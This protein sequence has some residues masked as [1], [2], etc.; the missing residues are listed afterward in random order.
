MVLRGS[1]YIGIDHLWVKRKEKNNRDKA[2]KIENGEIIKKA[3]IIIIV[4]IEYAQW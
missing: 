4:V 1:S 3:R 2:W